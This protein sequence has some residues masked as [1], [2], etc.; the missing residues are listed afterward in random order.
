MFDLFGGPTHNTK[1]ADDSLKQS[2]PIATV[3]NG[4]F[5]VIKYPFSLLGNSFSAAAEHGWKF[6]LAGAAGGGV[7]ALADG[8][9]GSD[10]IPMMLGGSVLAGVGGAVTVAA[11]STVFEVGKD[12]FGLLPGGGSEVQEPLSPSQTPHVAQTQQNAKG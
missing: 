6:A 1:D 9:S 8:K 4:A 3:F 12:V 10:V 11:G 7:K 5:N 2:G